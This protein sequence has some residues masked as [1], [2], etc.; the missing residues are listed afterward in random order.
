MGDNFDDQRS[1]SS[2]NYTKKTYNTNQKDKK[3]PNYN[4]NKKYTEHDAY[5]RK[6]FNKN[7]D[8]GSTYN[9]DN[10]YNAVTRNYVY[11]IYAIYS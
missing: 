3:V 7:S 9:D 11:C 2:H 1:Y 4:F 5:V 10:S 6:G 8:S